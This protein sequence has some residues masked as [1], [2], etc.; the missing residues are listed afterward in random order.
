MNSIIVPDILFSLFGQFYKIDQIV[1]ELKTI[2]GAADTLVNLMSQGQYLEEC[3]QLLKRLNATDI[4][5]PLENLLDSPQQIVQRYAILILADTPNIPKSNKLKQKLCQWLSEIPQPPTNETDCIDLLKAITRLVKMGEI[6]ED[7]PDRLQSI[8][9][10]I[11]RGNYAEA[12]WPKA[13]I[14][15]SRILYKLG[16][17]DKLREVAC[18]QNTNYLS[19][20]C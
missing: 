19:R 16:Y 8:L 5:I 3:Y 9:Y 13:W 4:A 18:S 10:F 12:Y 1:Q 15:T 7:I 14:E 6:K 11:P 17:I 20:A 2:P